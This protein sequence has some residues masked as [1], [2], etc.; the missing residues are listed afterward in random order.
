M[1]L[2]AWVDAYLSHLRVE[3]ALAANTVEAYAHDLAKLCEHAEAE[4]GEH[5]DVTALD[6]R[7]VSTYLVKLGEAGLGARSAARH[8][9]AV[10]GFAKFLVRERALGADP[11]ALIDRPR[12]GRR[13]PKVLTTGDIGEILEAPEADTFRGL[14]DRAMVHVM[15]AAGLRVS[16]LVGL[17]LG[18]LDLRKGLVMPL[19]KGQKRRL[20]P[21]GEPALDALDAYLKE[22]ARHAKA[23]GTAVVFLSPR[24]GALTRQAA[25]KMITRYARA[26]GISKPSSPHKLRHSFAT[27]LLEGGADLRSVQTLLGHASIATTEVYTHL[28]DDHVRA[29][30]RKAH[31]R[32]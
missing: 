24:G 21:L 10:R 14:R 17:K 15:Y 20:V 16:E 28:A 22:R 1:D 9:S 18:D 5:A 6:E 29:A 12:V 2:G 11:C 27:H 31:P 26:V 30:Y 8:L 23:Q 3:R 19:G 13:L 25:W 32:A 7:L 4:R